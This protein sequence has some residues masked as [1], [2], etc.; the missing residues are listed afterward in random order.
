MFGVLCAPDSVGGVGCDCATPPRL[1][2]FFLFKTVYLIDSML[3]PPPAEAT[4]PG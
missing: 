1:R 2:E 3:F 4:K